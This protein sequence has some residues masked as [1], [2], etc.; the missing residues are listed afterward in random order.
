[1]LWNSTEV[2][3]SP[4]LWMQDQYNSEWETLFC[5]VCLVTTMVEQTTIQVWNSKVI[6]LGRVIRHRIVSDS[7]PQSIRVCRV[8][9]APQ[10]CRLKP[11]LL[12][13]L[14]CTGDL[15]RIYRLVSPSVFQQCQHAWFYSRQ[16]P[17]LKKQRLDAR[18]LLFLLHVLT[19]SKP[20]LVSSLATFGPK[21]L[22][23]RNVGRLNDSNVCV[24]HHSLSVIIFRF[25]C[26]CFVFLI[27][28]TQTTKR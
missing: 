22:A 10:W 2:K 5:M 28:L 3:R 17:F 1:M 7:F 9:F 18:F 24:S 14:K 16:N 26:V 4:S 19:G 8:W 15:S 21:C 25:E 12:R 27:A 13:S 6:M 23:K 11:K 20:P